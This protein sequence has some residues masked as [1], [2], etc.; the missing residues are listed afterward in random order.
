[1]EETVS[2]SGNNY[3]TTNEY[4][5]L[6][7]NSPCDLELNLTEKKYDISFKVHAS[8]MSNKR[9]N[10]TSFDDHEVRSTRICSLDTIDSKETNKNNSNLLKRKLQHTN[11]IFNNGRW[12]K[13]E[14]IKF[15]EAILLYGND[16]KQIQDHVQSRSSAQARSHSQKFFMKLNKSKSLA[17][18]PDCEIDIKY[19]HNILRKMSYNDYCK[20]LRILHEAPFAKIKSKCKKSLVFEEQSMVANSSEPHSK[21][22]EILLKSNEAAFNE[23]Y[24]TEINNPVIY[25][26]SNNELSAES[27]NLKKSE[28]N[29]QDIDYEL[30]HSLRI[31]KVFFSE[32]SL[33]S[34]TTK[35]CNRLKETKEA[36]SPQIFS[37]NANIYNMI[38]PEEIECHPLSFFDKPDKEFDHCLISKNRNNCAAFAIT[39]NLENLQIPNNCNLQP[40]NLTTVMTDC[41]LYS[42]NAN[43]IV[44]NDIEDIG[45]IKLYPN[46]FHERDTTNQLFSSFADQDLFL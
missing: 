19:I 31:S 21:D 22:P 34:E 27:I 32:A 41:S 6:W 4:L 38:E 29:Y 2:S 14:H 17:A 28:S 23:D 37:S 16:W 10:E 18:H 45:F 5:T 13:E 1:M 40:I 9:I 25:F 44:G 15:V 39:E 36:C 42:F 33:E 3:N 20:T 7:D 35:I 24:S 46:E 43:I 26:E 12:T 11:Q 30:N 8:K